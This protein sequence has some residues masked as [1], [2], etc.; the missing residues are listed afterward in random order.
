MRLQ[1]DETEKN[2]VQFKDALSHT[3]LLHPNLT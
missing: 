2:E 1:Q 3:N